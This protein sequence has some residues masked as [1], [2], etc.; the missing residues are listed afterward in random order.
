[1]DWGTQVHNEA[2]Q[3]RNKGDMSEAE[4]LREKSEDLWA[5][6]EKAYDDAKA[7]APNYVQTHHQ[8]GLLFL[9][10]AEAAQAWGDTA[11]AKELYDKAYH[12]FE[13]YHMLD[14]V[15][16]PNYD[17]MAQV[18]LL[19]GDFDEA[20]RLYKEAIY[21]NDVVARSIHPEPFADR[22]GALSTSLAKIYFN[23]ANHEQK[24][25][26][27]PVSPSV[28]EAIKYFR[29][30]VTSTPNNAEAWKGLAFL[31]QKTG[32]NDEAAQAVAK[33]RALEPNNPNLNINPNPTINNSEE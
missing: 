9:K 11:R 29:L 1:N 4:R 12:N 31:L 10:R 15:F 22:V 26:F 14:P 17:R 32:Q 16:P 28:L 6:S 19:R 33:A 2:I 8:V 25:P 5:K 3:A 21:Y 18:L 24:D 30:A 20:I 7:L 13:L 23:K 27:N